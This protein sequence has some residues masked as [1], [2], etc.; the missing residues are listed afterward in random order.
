MST[1]KGIHIL[2]DPFANQFV[3]HKLHVHGAQFIGRI[4]ISRDPGPLTKFLFNTPLHHHL[5][6]SSTDTAQCC[7]HP[8]WQINP[9]SDVL[10]TSNQQL[11]RA[12]NTKYRNRAEKYWKLNQKYRNRIVQFLIP[13][14][15]YFSS[16]QR[17]Y[18]GVTNW[19][20]YQATSRDQRSP[21]R[22]Q[23]RK[24]SSQTPSSR[25]ARPRPRA[26]LH[27]L[28]RIPRS[29][30]LQ[31]C[32]TASPRPT[33]RRPSAAS[34]QQLVRSQVPIFGCTKLILSRW[35]GI[36]AFHTRST[37]TTTSVA[38]CAPKISH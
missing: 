27:P 8:K 4:V 10:L 14:N 38:S 34:P 22:A 16:V 29:A 11:D 28:R 20:P 2:S 19:V 24:Y 37:T 30:R 33:R 12:R 36:P 23:E 13:R 5:N 6:P 18:R 3:F 17:K 32:A 31:P 1:L 15:R 25:F 9:K 35:R 21:S 7:G 26:A